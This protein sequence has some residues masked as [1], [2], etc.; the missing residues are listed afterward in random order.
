MAACHWISELRGK[1]W[2]SK[3]GAG[4][5]L[6]AETGQMRS[7]AKSH[8]KQDVKI[9]SEIGLSEHGF[10]LELANQLFYVLA[11][12]PADKLKGV[13]RPM[14]RSNNKNSLKAE[15]PKAAASQLYGCQRMWLII[16]THG[17]RCYLWPLS[18]LWKMP[19]AAAQAMAQTKAPLSPRLLP[20]CHGVIEEGAFSS[21]P[22]KHL[23]A[24]GVL[25]FQI[26]WKRGHSS[27]T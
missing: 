11:L 25:Q 21:P 7:K 10:L 12:G 16:H 9:T 4:K 6:N 23:L 18:P 3:V 27:C 24:I 1:T 2:N 13:M 20:Q 8:E 19:R 17:Q 22:S 15:F 26:S 5:R 14:A